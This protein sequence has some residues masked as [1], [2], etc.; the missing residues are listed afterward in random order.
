MA[1]L[2]EQKIKGRIYLYQ[3]ENFWDTQKKQSRQKRKYLGPKERVYKRK[4]DTSQ[5]WE[6]L[7]K[8]GLPIKSY[9]KGFLS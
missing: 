5:T 7:Q 2:V 4:N 1:Y 8:S 3:V 6:A 9:K